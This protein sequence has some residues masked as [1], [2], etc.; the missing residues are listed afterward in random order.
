MTERGRARCSVLSIRENLEDERLI[1][2]VWGADPDIQIVHVECGDEAL[3]Y[4]QRPDRRIPNLILL[5][6][7]FGKK[8]MTAI[9]TLTALKADTLLRPV[10]AIVLA[11]LLSPFHIDELYAEQ[12]A[13]VFEMP[14]DV[15]LLASV[16]H[17]I[18]DLWMHTASLPYRD[19]TLLR[20]QAALT[21]R[22]AEIVCLSA[23]DL[24]NKEIAA[25]LGISIKTVE[26]HRHNICR[27]LG[28]RGT[29]GMVRYAIRNRLIYA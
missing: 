29:A 13:C 4:L 8:R 9:E 18:K 15:G 27:R 25:R 5:G 1:E 2:Q 12:V 24:A 10:P 16:L 6:W 26:F 14:H 19:G 20:E 17:T 11:G 23:E 21:E 22:E 3:E 7:Q 28:V